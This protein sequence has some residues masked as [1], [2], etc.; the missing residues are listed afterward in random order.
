MVPERSRTD[1]EPVAGSRRWGFHQALHHHQG[2]HI[3]KAAVMKGPGQ[4]ADDPEALA[5]PAL[6]AGLVG[7]HHQVELHGPE[8]Q[9]QGLRQGVAAQAAA[10]ALPSPLV[11]HHEAGVG[12]VGTK[13][14][15][16]RTEVVGAHH[17]GSGIHGHQNAL[18]LIHPGRAGLLLADRRVVGEG[19]TGPEHRLQQRPERR[20][21]G[22]HVGA[23]HHGRTGMDRRTGGSAA[24]HHGN[25]AR[26]WGAR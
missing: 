15:R 14:G 13:G 16:V 3:P 11:G 25:P 6:D 1:D 23:D 22:R 24:S 19:F 10:D 5:L 8:P 12:H 7:A 21:V 9:P 2:I 26:L 18:V 17:G 20:P 4:D